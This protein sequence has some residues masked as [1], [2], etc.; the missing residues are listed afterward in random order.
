MLFKF[1]REIICKTELVDLEKGLTEL[2]IF[3]KEVSEQIK[4]ENNYIYIIINNKYGQE[5]N[6]LKDSF[7]NS[8]NLFIYTNDSLDELN[9]LCERYLNKY[10]YK[11]K[12]RDNRT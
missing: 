2:E 4:H 1:L 11:I 8:R 9:L 12:I 5:K 10:C 7:D 6:L 3:I